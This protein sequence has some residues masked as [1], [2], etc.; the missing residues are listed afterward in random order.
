MAE[1]LL[2]TQCLIVLTGIR[3]KWLL[4]ALITSL[5]VAP[6]LFLRSQELRIYLPGFI[7]FAI[8]WPVVT[9]MVYFGANLERQMGLA[10]VG[11][12]VALGLAGACL[13]TIKRQFL[14]FGSAVIV[15]FLA[16]IYGFALL[17]GVEIFAA[18]GERSHQ[19]MQEVDR[20]IE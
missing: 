16:V 17:S 18:N 3:I 7:Y 10:S 2:N 4:F 20:A 15:L 19:I 6:L 11:P 9:M 13:L 5:L 14:N 1:S 12:S 8:L